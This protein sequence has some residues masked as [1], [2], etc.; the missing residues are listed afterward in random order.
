MLRNF[1]GEGGGGGGLEVFSSIFQALRKCF[2]DPIVSKSFYAACRF[3]RKQAKKRVF[4]HFLDKF[5]QKN[6]FFGTRSP[7][8]LVILTPKA[9]F[10]KFGG[11][12]WMSL[13]YTKKGSF[14]KT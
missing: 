9:P 4:R 11:Q 6:S 3:F 12:N 8:N 2:K 13:N 5:D 10:E 14:W 7:T 1:L